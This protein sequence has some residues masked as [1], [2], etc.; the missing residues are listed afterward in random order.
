MLHTSVRKPGDIQN[1]Q[2]ILNCMSTHLF[3]DKCHS[4]KETPQRSYDTVL[5]SPVSLSLQVIYAL[6]GKGDN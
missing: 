2:I 4:W 3:T 1:D 6:E 5:S